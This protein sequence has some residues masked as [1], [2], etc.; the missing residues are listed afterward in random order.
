MLFAGIDIGSLTAEAVVIEDGE[1]AGS[2]IMAVSPNPV[3]SA[4]KVLNRLVE[5]HGVDR[6]AI[7]YTVSTGYGREAIEQAGLANENLSEISCHG[8]GAFRLEPGVRTVV[9]IGGQDAKVIRVDSAGK[10]E[11]FVMND[12]CAAGTGH[13]LEVMSR[14]L[15]LSL[16]RIGEV[17]L[18]SRKPVEVSSR[19]TIY[20]ET[21]VN[22][23]RQRG[24]PVADIAAGINRAMARRVVALIR[25]V[26]PEPE[27]MVT[28]GVAKNDAVRRELE[29]E[30]RLN[31]LFPGI[32][33]QLVGAYGAA[34]YAMQRGATA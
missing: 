20:V 21:E 17:S 33:P 29:K 1:M 31:V 18:R 7:A 12:K 16:D 9:D 24:V 2:E 11:D 13:F 15:D 5:R 10:L 23:F 19:C 32:D 6:R 14:A 30:L 8:Y 34:A 22:H 28:G 4:N 25:R 27:L 26:R 3:D